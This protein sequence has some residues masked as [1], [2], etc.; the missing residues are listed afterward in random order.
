VPVVPGVEGHRSFIFSLLSGG[1][2]T[3]SGSTL[4]AVVLAS[5]PDEAG[6]NGLLSSSD[7]ITYEEDLL[8]SMKH[9]SMNK[10]RIAAASLLT[11]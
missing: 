5:I 8:S 11:Y 2:C 3:H 6:F 10:A 4:Y 9:L 7:D 1:I